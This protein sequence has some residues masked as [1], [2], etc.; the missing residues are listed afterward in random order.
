MTE[1]ALREAPEPQHAPDSTFNDLHERYFNDLRGFVRRRLPDRDIADDITQETFFRAFRSRATFDPERPA[2]PWLVTI[3]R[4]LISN[5]MRDERR[6]LRHMADNIDLSELEEQPDGHTENQ[7]E[8]SFSTNEHRR[9]IQDALESLPERQRRMLLLRT[10]ADLNYQE[11][12]DHEGVTVDASKSLVKRARKAFRDAYADA[13]GERGLGA[14]VLLPMVKPRRAVDAAATMTASAVETGSQ[15]AMAVAATAVLLASSLTA[16]RVVEGLAGPSGVVATVSVDLAKPPAAAPSDR[17]TE[18][19]KSVAATST[20]PARHQIDPTAGGDGP[21][22]DTV[23]EIAAAPDR[24][25]RLD[26]LP[27][28]PE[29]AGEPLVLDAPCV[30]TASILQ[31]CLALIGVGTTPP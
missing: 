28:Q 29:T 12:A 3:A 15:L 25:I 7:P 19:E 2:W 13:A 26:L 11:I 4:N 16:E 23:D 20:T 30:E 18:Q 22:G 9:V 6:R 1:P 8:D 27:G 14:V 10:V 21:V 31:P 5:R 17:A 24:F